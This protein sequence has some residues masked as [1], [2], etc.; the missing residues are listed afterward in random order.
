[1]E[2]WRLLD[3]FSWCIN[4]GWYSLWRNFTIFK[5][6]FRGIQYLTQFITN[7]SVRCSD[8]KR[9]VWVRLELVD[10]SSM[11][12]TRV[13]V[14]SEI[15]LYC[16]VSR[17][18]QSTVLSLSASYNIPKILVTKISWSYWQKCLPLTFLYHHY[19]N[20]VARM[21]SSSPG[22]Y[23]PQLSH[24]GMIPW[25]YSPDLMYAISSFF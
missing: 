25:Q 17:L 10:Q 5:I 20:K 21:S 4:L 18:W 11:T 8:A 3:G 6:L 2:T 23:W 19:L 16:D 1:M 24:Q 15:M 14:T 7:H 13:T 12:P 9:E 22:E